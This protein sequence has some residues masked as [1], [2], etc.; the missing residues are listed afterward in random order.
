MSIVTF[1]LM[2][3][4]DVEAQVRKKAPSKKSKKQQET[5]EVV[6]P[7]TEKL[8]PELKFGN[9]GFFNGFSISSKAN[10]GYKISNHFTAGIG[11]K[12]F[13]DQV[14]AI[15]SDPSNFD[16]GGFVYT[17]GKVTQEI[18]IQAEYAFM[19]YDFFNTSVNY[20]LI[21]LGYMSGVNNWRFGVELLYIASESARDYQGS[22]VEYWFGASMNF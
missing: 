7:F 21:G 18:Y 16:Y 11:G 10:V 12:L 13:Y 15:G 4:I 9:L 20:P 17:R 6:V 1:L 14:A 3:A 5:S 22:V 2:G 19:K 8:N